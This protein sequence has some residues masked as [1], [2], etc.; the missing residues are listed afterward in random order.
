MVHASQTL[1]A[2]DRAGD[3]KLDGLVP[4]DHLLRKIEGVID[5]SFIHDRLPGFIART[6]GDRRSIRH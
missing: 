5:F 1:A 4:K 2:T 6:T 3:G